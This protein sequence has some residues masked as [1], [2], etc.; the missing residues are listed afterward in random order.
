MRGRVFRGTPDAL[1]IWQPWLAPR[2]LQDKGIP[3][4]FDLRTGRLIFFH[5]FTLPTNTVSYLIEGEKGSGKS[6]FQKSITA[7]CSMLQ[8]RDVYNNPTPWRTRINSRKPEQGISE[9]GPL[10]EA[11]H[12]PVYN[13]ASGPKINLLGLFK[14]ESDIIDVSINLVQ[15]VSGRKVGE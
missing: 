11:L 13:L 1:S 14:N 9:Y 12:S 6:T 4:G 10:T 7:R 3:L 15:E 2:H 5:P 8:A